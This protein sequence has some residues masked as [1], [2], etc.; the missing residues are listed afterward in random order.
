MSSP[1][2]KRAKATV[3]EVNARQP[4]SPAGAFPLFE[5]VGNSLP[6]HDFKQLSLSV[7]IVVY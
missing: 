3:I 7:L 2:L 4:R 6:P 1:F 5:F